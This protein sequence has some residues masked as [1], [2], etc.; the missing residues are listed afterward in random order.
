[1]KFDASLRLFHLH[2]EGMGLVIIV[3]TMTAATLARPGV[4]RRA[5]LVLLT[6]GGAGYPVRLSALGRAH[7]LP[8]AC[9][10][11]RPSPSGW[12]GS[13][14][15]VRPSWRPGGSR[16]W[17]ARASSGGHEALGVG[18][19]PRAG[20]GHRGPARRPRRRPGRGSSRRRLRPAR[21]RGLRQL[22]ADQVRDPGAEA[23]RRPPPLR[24]RRPPR[25]DA[26]AGRPVARG[27]RGAGRARR[28]PRAT[29]LAPSAG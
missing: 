23:R 21:Q 19:D 7:P 5:L 15:A 17:S 14:S 3:T 24:V 12:S 1:M 22:Q 6:A 4:G 27:P 10:R 18:R 29:G 20:S 13:P 28:S 8:R 9:R 25:R 26:G 16:P 11:P 2:A